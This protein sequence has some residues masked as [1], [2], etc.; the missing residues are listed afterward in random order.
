[1][2]PR[3]AVLDAFERPYDLGNKKILTWLLSLNLERAGERWPEER[4]DY[5]YLDGN[6][7]Y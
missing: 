5:A 1:M 3:S 6:P 4:C 7:T 2:T